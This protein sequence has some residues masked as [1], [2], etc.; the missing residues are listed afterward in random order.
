MPGLRARRGEDARRDLA[1]AVREREIEVG[2][3][4]P[5]A[6]G[7]RR[8]RFGTFRSMTRK[9]T[10]W[11]PLSLLALCV[12]LLLTGCF[13]TAADWKRVRFVVDD[14]RFEGM[15]ENRTHWSVVVAASNPTGKRLKLEGLQLAAFLDANGRPDT[16]ATLVNSK[17]ID[18]SPRDTTQ[19]TL[20]LV[21]P[22][23]AWDKALQGMQR[24]GTQEVF[25]TGDAFVK[26]WFGTRKVKNAFKKTYEVDL[27]TLMGSMG[28]DLLRNL[29]FR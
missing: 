29:F 14:V 23:S 11:F 24:S 13:A 16:L 7:M 27:A 28:G 9:L 20:N 26:T 2:V 8:G 19:V 12:P 3:A 22:P 4:I 18:L 10:T 1:A 21:L 17:N 15:R 5:E 6:G 25:I